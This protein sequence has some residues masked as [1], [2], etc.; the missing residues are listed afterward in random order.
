MN[1]LLKKRDE[2]YYEEIKQYVTDLPDL[3]AMDAKSSA[4]KA[5]LAKR[6][7]D[8]EAKWCAIL[9]DLET[10]DNA[11]LRGEDCKFDIEFIDMITTVRPLSEDLRYLPYSWSIRI[12]IHEPNGT[13]TV[14]KIIISYFII[15]CIYS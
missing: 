10:L 14:Y 13:S 11:S 4:M 3:L 1:N 12:I 7:W 8:Q 9:A 2:K 6:L 5:S 15:Q